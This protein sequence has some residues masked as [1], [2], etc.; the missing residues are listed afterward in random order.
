MLLSFLLVYIFSLRL[1][2]ALRLDRACAGLHPDDFIMLFGAV[3]ASDANVVSG[4]AIYSRIVHGQL[5][6]FIAHLLTARLEC[7]VVDALEVSVL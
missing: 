1:L 5:L 2:E 3:R 4:A 6:E 7:V